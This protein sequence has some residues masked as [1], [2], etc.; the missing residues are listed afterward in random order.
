MSK[1]IGQVA[2]QFIT[3]ITSLLPA[4]YSSKTNATGFWKDHGRI[5]SLNSVICFPSLIEIASLP[6]K[7]ILLIWLS[8]FI[9]THGQLSLAATCSIW[10]DLPVPWYP[11]ISTHL[12]EEK[13][14]SYLYLGQG[15]DNHK[16]HL[17]TTKY[18]FNDNLSPIG[19][20]YW[21]K[22]VQHFFQK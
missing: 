12:L 10:V 22:L 20:N 21:V 8:R 18:D 2:F 17:Q 11:C 5:P 9:L 6:I 1:Y 3:N 15:D 16:A 14:G 19:V 4:S 13:P 7:S